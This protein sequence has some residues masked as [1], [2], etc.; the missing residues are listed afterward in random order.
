M[1]CE[2][3]N[4]WKK[5]F[6]T[7]PLCVYIRKLKERGG[8]CTAERQRYTV[9]QFWVFC[10]RRKFLKRKQV[11]NHNFFMFRVFIVYCSNFD[12]FLHF[13]I[14]FTLIFAKIRLST[15]NENIYFVK[16]FE[17]LESKYSCFDNFLVKSGFPK[18]TDWYKK[19][20]TSVNFNI[21]WASFH[22]NL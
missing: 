1:I 21:S 5:I 8:G 19:V 22:E 7:M 16:V 15:Y 10:F 9:F 12:C 14:W 17:Q 4:G 6:G 20:S 18:V 2:F 11:K 13:F 3:S